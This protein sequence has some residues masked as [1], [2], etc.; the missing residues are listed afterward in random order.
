MVLLVELWRVIVEDN[1]NQTLKVKRCT[2]HT[3]ANEK[4]D[5]LDYSNGP[6][7]VEPISIDGSQYI[8][9]LKKHI[10]LCLP[11]IPSILVCFILDCFNHCL[12]VVG[13]S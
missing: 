10:G 13:I 2:L 11:S 5:I 6:L 3:C 4:E 12:N 1:D 9:V 8:G 7:L